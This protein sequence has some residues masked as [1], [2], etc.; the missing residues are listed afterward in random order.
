[1]FWDN[2]FTPKPFNCGFLPE[3]DGHA[4]YFAEFGNP[5]GIPVIVFHGGPGG[6][7]HEYRASYANLRKY[8]VIM[9]DQRGSGR[10][11]PLGKLEHNTTADLLDDVTRLI[12]YLKI[13][14]K[15]ILWGG[16][17]GSTL[18]LLWAEQ[19]PEMTDKLLL[20]QVFLANKEYLDWEFNG[21]KY[22]YPEFV[23]VMEKESNGKIKDYYNK[24]ILSDNMDKQLQA[25]NRY[26]WFERICG[27]QEPSFSEFSEVSP[28]ELASQRIY[29]HYSANNFFLG[30][31][32]ILN[33]ISKINHLEAVIIHSRLDFI[34]PLKGAYDI[35]Q[36]LPK[37]R[38][39]ILPAFG[40]V[41]RLMRMTIKRE[42]SKVLK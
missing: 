2:W 6:C 30:E 32:D 41:N 15:V 35:H 13:N 21:N 38:L 1:M 37:S 26:G 27:S 40:H 8:R 20:S 16:S 24:L 29:M 23:A 3:K 28:Q 10:S 5:Q 36:K 9:F 14:E 17:W 39:I 25:I 4:V 42:F 18:A 33:N 19:N 12:N 22:N 31:D 7:F 34:G 11:L